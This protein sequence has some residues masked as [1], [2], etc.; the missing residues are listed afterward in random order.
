MLGVQT[1]AVTPS[2]RLQSADV[3]RKLCMHA[4]CSWKH[5]GECLGL[6]NKLG[7]GVLYFNTFLGSGFLI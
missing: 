4:R 7:F 6:N 5:E 1:H 3:K 2:K